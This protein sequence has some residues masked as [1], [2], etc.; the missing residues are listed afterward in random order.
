M[1]RRI[2]RFLSVLL[3]ILGALV[4]VA[5]L[6]FASF[7]LILA[8]PQPDKDAP[9]EPQPVLTASPAVNIQYETERYMSNFHTS[10][11]MIYK[12]EVLEDDTD[13]LLILN[14]KNK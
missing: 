8:Q 9:A 13:D 14:N 12:T 1:P 2:P 4:T 10:L 3:K 11:G 5:A 7:S 6:A